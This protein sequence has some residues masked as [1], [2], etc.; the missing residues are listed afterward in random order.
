MIDR[1]LP[2]TEDELH[3]YVDGEL[4]AD[5]KEAVTAWLA[6]HPE[7][8]AQVGAWLAQAEA[9]RAR[10]GAVA[11]EPVPERLKLDQVIRRDR[12]N[13]RSWA[14]VAAAA[15]IVAF[16]AGGAAG[17]MAHGASAAGP[18]GFDL[19]ATEAL[20]AYKLY[21]VEVRHPVEV[22]GSERAHL[23]QWLS[24]RLGSE[25]RVPEL[26]SIGL[27]LVGGRLLPGPTGAAA[28]YMYEGPSGE[29]FTIYC[30]KVAMAQT[31]LHYKS[32]NS[33]AA[34]YWVD[35]KVAYVVSGPADRDRLEMVTKSV[36]E[37]VDKTG[38]KKS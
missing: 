23:T 26:Q 20:D 4:P 6:A 14:A 3:A 37:Q 30:A 31:A 15:A 19:F 32:D 16:V 9:V 2:V 8:A 10:Y 21:V 36:Y 35:D 28:F 12:S 29:R 24:K 22:P 34:F 17:W 25:L 5:R 11:S 1:D 13:G 18:T 27:K 38:A 33:F 7:H